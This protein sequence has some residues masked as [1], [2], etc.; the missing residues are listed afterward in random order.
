[1]RMFNL[2]LLRIILF[3]IALFALSISAHA[4]E[5]AFFQ[6]IKGKWA[7]PGEIVAGKYKGTKFTCVFDGMTPSKASGMSIDGYCRVGVFSQR[8]NADVTKRGRR[9]LGKFLDGEKGEGMNITGGRYSKNKFIADIKRKKL[10]G[11]M[12]A[13]KVGKDKLQVTISVRVGGKLVP[14]I[15]MGLNRKSSP[16]LARK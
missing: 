7:G 9:F 8:I 12:I 3:P 11:A 14:V 6:S 4:S 13:R 2:Q 1:M 15:G 16:K 5:R 10:R